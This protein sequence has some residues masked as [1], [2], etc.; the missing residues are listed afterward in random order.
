VTHDYD[1]VVVGA[2]HAGCEA[3]V[4]CARLGLRTALVTVKLEDTARCR[5]TQCGGIAKDLVA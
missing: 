2:G 4:V 1:V 5:A 3:A